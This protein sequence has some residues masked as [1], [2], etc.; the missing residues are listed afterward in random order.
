MLLSCY[1]KCKHFVNCWINWAERVSGLVLCL[2]R[3]FLRHHY[4]VNGLWS[5]SVLWQCS[6]KIVLSTLTWQQVA[7]LPLYEEPKNKFKEKCA[8]CCKAAAQ[9]PS[10]WEMTEAAK[11]AT[12]ALK[13]TKKR[14]TIVSQSTSPW[15][16]HPVRA[17]I[18]W[19]LLTQV[20]K[21][22]QWNGRRCQMANPT[23]RNHC[24]SY[25]SCHQP[26][27]K[28]HLRAVSLY[29]LWGDSG[30]RLIIVQ[31]QH[32]K[33]PYSQLLTDLSNSNKS[34]KELYC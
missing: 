18:R 5:T 14:V 26:S 1:L 32:K 11:A 12:A 24:K 17:Q 21:N 33:K 20:Y 4:S 28:L 27:D 19:Y 6:L 22:P 34:N 9:Q 3:S 7:T 8:S 23:K 29:P 13:G 30:I 10:G 31:S 2:S 16:S 15:V 25:P